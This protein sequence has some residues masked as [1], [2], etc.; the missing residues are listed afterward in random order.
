M[1]KMKI[2]NTGLLL[3]YFLIQSCSYRTSELC[4]YVLAPISNEKEY[5]Q[6]IDSY[7]QLVD[8]CSSF[9]KNKERGN[10]KEIKIAAYFCNRKPI[11]VQLTHY[12]YS[13]HTIN[14]YSNY[15]YLDKKL[16]Y[17]RSTIFLEDRITKKKT[18]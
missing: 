15:Y 13:E 11:Q 17:Y 8:S 9:L 7:V 16:V 4:N 1:V 3:G 10:I 14:G 18:G 2:K 5:I 12:H 6:A